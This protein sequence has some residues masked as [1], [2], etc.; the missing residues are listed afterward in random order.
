M[1]TKFPMKFVSTDGNAFSLLSRFISG[2]KKA[3]WEKA[4]IDSVT[5]EATSGDYS[6]LLRTLTENT[7]PE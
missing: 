2:A 7:I 3:G 1:K 4:D 5:S 6:H